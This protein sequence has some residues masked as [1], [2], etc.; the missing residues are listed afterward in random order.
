MVFDVPSGSIARHELIDVDENSSVLDAAKRM[1]QEDRGSV[2]ATRGG[3]R[4]GILT[5][6]DLL[7]KVLAKGLDPNKTKVKDAMTSPPISV[8]EKE[9]LRKAIEL[10]NRKGVRR[11]L[12]TEH[13]KVTGI[14]T[15]RDII[16]YTRTCAHC[17]Q[18]I[19]SILEG[20][21][22]EPYIECECGTRYHRRCSET[23]VNCVNCSRTLVTNVVYPEPSETFSG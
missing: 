23:V 13:G 22:A 19:K 2:I 18:E 7:R 1:V 10:M 11:M 3:E 12:V 21:K 17:G 8:D 6:R 4:V 16:K 20:E 14:F 9:P 5:E 15:L